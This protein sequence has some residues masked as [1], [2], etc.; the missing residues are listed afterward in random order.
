MIGSWLKHWLRYTVLL[1][2]ILTGMALYFHTE[3]PANRMPDFSL[4]IILNASYASAARLHLS[5][6]R[7]EMSVLFFFGLDDCPIC[8]FEIEHWATARRDLENMPINL[9]GITYTTNVQQITEFCDEYRIDFPICLDT[10]KDIL[11]KI[12]QKLGAE[13]SNTPFKVVLDKQAKI[14]DWEKPEKETS[15]REVATKIKNYYK[16]AS[17]R[18]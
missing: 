10:N 8:L 6:I 18:K 7:G 16:R 15:V 3:Q 4:P 2:I 5:D 12:Q 17:S 9:I 14:I 11:R 13:Y 1:L